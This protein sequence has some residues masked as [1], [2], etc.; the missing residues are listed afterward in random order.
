MPTYSDETKNMVARIFVRSRIS[1]NDIASL[2][3]V[4]GVTVR[5]WA[6]KFYP[7]EYETRKHRTRALLQAQSIL[8]VQPNIRPPEL[9]KLVDVPTETI[10]SWK[11]RGVIELDV[12]CIICG[13]PTT[14]KYCDE[15]KEKNWHLYKIKYPEVTLEELRIVDATTECAICGS[16][17]PLEFDHDH[18]TGKFRGMLCGKCNRGLGLFNDDTDLLKSAIRYLGKKKINK[19]KNKIKF[20]I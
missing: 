4:T 3:G 9:S 17:E 1:A 2:Y 12:Q 15:C 19:I 16:K 11:N 18:S 10:Y 20:L 7:D 5:N 8:E 6:K 13:E 14:E